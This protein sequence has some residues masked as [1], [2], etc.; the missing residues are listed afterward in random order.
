MLFC[1]VAWGG[2][3]S[4]NKA[5]GRFVRSFT[6]AYWNVG[7]PNTGTTEENTGTPMIEIG[8]SPYPSRA[9]T[10]NPVGVRGKL[11][12][13]HPLV[14]QRRQKKSVTSVLR[15]AT[16]IAADIMIGLLTRQSL[17]YRPRWST[18]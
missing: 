7:I 17:M 12:S 2:R 5:N 15:P 13:F 11:S 9:R 3:T 6:G 4:V 16:G 14:F 10:V 1:D 18:R 8:K